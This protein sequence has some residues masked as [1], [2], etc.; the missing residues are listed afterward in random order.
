MD[1]FLI[2]FL[3]VLSYAFFDRIAVRANQEPE[4]FIQK[5][6]ASIYQ[7]LLGITICIPVILTINMP[8]GYSLP[9]EK[10]VQDSIDSI[11]AAIDEAKSSDGE[12]LFI[13]ERQ[14]LMFD[15]VTGIEMVPDYE[16]VFLMEMAMANNPNYLNTFYDELRSH[17][18]ALIISEPLKLNRQ[19]SSYSFGEE[20]NAWV[21]RVSGPVLCY[22]EPI[23]TLKWVRT[24][25]LV[26][27]QDSGDCPAI[28]Q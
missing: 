13:S 23:D 1:A 11:Q 10:I 2:L 4:Q 17:R 5:S 28:T 6:Y 22:Y 12:V 19:D 20:N 15:T 27:R 21:E 25:L 24:E 26:P 8:A 9:G 14:L 16:K 7:V 18:F 3:V